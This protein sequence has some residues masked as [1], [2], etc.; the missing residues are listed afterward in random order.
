[1]SIMKADIFKYVTKPLIGGG[2]VM[3]Y[4]SIIENRTYKYDI[5]KRDA[6]VMAGSV[7]SSSILYDV[8]NRF[9]EF[10]NNDVLKYL[11]EPLINAAI[12]SYA[13]ER[14]LRNT[15]SDYVADRSNMKNY[16]FGAIIQFITTYSTNP[17][18]GLFFGMKYY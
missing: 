6:V 11:L 10:D 4:G 15:Y 8:L 14:F 2:I 16:A 9:I 5:A 7:L 12:Y 17:L 18:M 3:L 13:Y 1:M